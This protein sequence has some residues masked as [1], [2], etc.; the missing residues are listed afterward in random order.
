MK[1]T[2]LALIALIPAV[3]HAGS[4]AETPPDKSAYSLF[5]PTPDGLLR[6]FDTDRPDKTNSPHTL[7]AGRFQLETGLTA[8]TRNKDSGVRTQNW[9]WADTMIRAGLTSSSE[10]QLE[11]PFFQTNSDRDLAAGKTDKASGIGDLTAILKTNF[12]GNDSGDTAGGM[13]FIVT[14]PTASHNL[15][16]GKVEGGALFLLGMKL[17]RDFDLGVNSGV[18]LG[19]DDD[20]KYEAEIINSVSVS[21]SI[22]GP[23]S[24][25]LEFYSSV[26]TSDAGN[27]EG[28]IDTGLLLML[29]KNVQLDTGVNF[30]VTSG[31]DDLQV[32]AGASIRF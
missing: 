9:T 29:G 31:A 30:G 12:W 8:Y 18:A 19:V 28:T 21:H 11:M 14:A 13:E 10:L 15:G 16:S 17:P 5:R 26:P 25:Y 24:A 23:L 2:A 20:D 22:V 4:S 6:D 3:L 27:W 32:F 7:D 1:T